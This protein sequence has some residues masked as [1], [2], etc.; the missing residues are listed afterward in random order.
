[1]KQLGIQ[2]DSVFSPFDNYDLDLSFDVD[3]SEILSTTQ[4][5]SLRNQEESL[6]ANVK[7]LGRERPRVFQSSWHEIGFI[8]SVSMSQ[9]LSV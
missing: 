9:I 3:I 2:P 6:N 1:M 7:K 5:Q 8:F 4:A